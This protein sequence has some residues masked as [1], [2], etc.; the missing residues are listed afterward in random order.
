MI[1]YLGLEMKNRYWTLWLVCVLKVNK[2]RVN[3]QRSIV[4]SATRIGEDHVHATCE[5]MNMPTP[6]PIIE[7]TAPLIEAKAVN[8]SIICQ[9][10]ELHSSDQNVSIINNHTLIHIY[11]TTLICDYPF[12]LVLHMGFFMVWNDFFSFRV[13]DLF[14][15]HTRS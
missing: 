2:D 10:P 12:K 6:L 4:R 8:F 3:C 9:V 13:L 1:I 5:H 15:W 7:L 11:V 14:T